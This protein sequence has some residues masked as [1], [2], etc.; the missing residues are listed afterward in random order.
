M[1]TGAVFNPHLPACL[2]RLTIEV[3]ACLE[4]EPGATGKRPIAAG[5][6]ARQDQ[7]DSAKFEPA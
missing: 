2:R 5:Y 1:P 4:A 7:T 6:D 3:A